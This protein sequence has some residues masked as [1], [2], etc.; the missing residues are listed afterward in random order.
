VDPLRRLEGGAA[1]LL[2]TAAI[3]LAKYKVTINAVM[4]ATS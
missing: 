1:R 2:R 4:P 3:E